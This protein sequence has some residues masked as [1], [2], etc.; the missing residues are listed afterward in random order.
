MARIRSSK[1]EFWTDPLMCSLPR[2]IR[3][4]FK[5]LWEV[6]A[7]D[8]GRFSGEVR[9]IKG[10][11]W[12]LDDDMTVK[13]LEKYLQVLAAN[14]RI[15]LYEV[16]G[17]R[18]G[19]IVN[20]HKHQRVTH[21][22]PS[23]YPDPPSESLRNGSGNPHESLRKDSALSGADR[24][25]EERIGAERR[26]RDAPRSE[27]PGNGPTADDIDP[28]VRDE[29]RANPQPRVQLP[30]PETS[31]FFERFYELGTTDK[32]RLDVRRQLYDALDSLAN[33]GRGARVRPGVF[34]RARDAAHLAGVMLKVID[35]PP[36]E[37]DSAIVFVLKKL[38]DPPPGPSPS[39]ERARVDT[40]T[41]A[42]EERYR[43]ARR[44]AGIAWSKAN[45]AA[46]EQIRLAVET[47]LADAKGGIGQMVKD[48]ALEQRCGAA[49]E[50]QSFDRWCEEHGHASTHGATP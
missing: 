44:S 24:I 4:T 14:G 15:L 41:I 42:L 16:G 21:P 33:S 26:G 38:G 49:A 40:E 45:P 47:D 30:E 25:G 20:W 31:R 1:P 19:Q 3:F 11:I 10:Q 5:G 50:F 35:D 23:R 48:A 8:Y 43:A 39:E 32:R 27:D 46:Y 18:Y 6:S 7:D 36:R 2:D 34:V 17:V 9:I 22:S 13:K 37:N 29:D 28:F 12:P